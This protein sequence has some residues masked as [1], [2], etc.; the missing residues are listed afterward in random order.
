MKSGATLALCAALFAGAFPSAAS[1]KK[2]ALHRYYAR[3]VQTR[4]VYSVY[5]SPRFFVPPQP[6][7]PL[8][9]AFCPTNRVNT[10]MY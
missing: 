6:S 8:C 10:H 2:S 9:F 7:R 5:R 4:T 1:A 3:H